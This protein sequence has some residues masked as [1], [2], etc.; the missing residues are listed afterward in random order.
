MFTVFFFFFLQEWGAW[1]RFDVE[2]YMII[3]MLF[4]DHSKSAVNQRDGGDKL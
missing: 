1:E 4:E 2:S 3:D